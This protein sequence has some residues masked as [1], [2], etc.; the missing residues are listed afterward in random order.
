MN[1][2]VVVTVNGT[3]WMVPRNIKLLAD[4]LR[5]Q[6]ESELREK[7][8]RASEAAQAKAKEENAR[9]E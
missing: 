6:A 7:A 4:A 1:D 3:N 5:S 9:H 2:K 8:R